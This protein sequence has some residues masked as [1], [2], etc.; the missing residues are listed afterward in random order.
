M[1]SCLVAS[2]AMVFVVGCGGGSGRSQGAGTCSPTALANNSAICQG[3]LGKATT[4]NAD[5]AKTVPVAI[6]NADYTG[7]VGY[8]TRLSTSSDYASFII[9]VTNVSSTARCF[10]SVSS[11]QA[12]TYDLSSYLTGSVGYYGAIY[13][14]TCLGPS[15]TGYLIDITNEVSYTDVSS[16]SLT[17]GDST[18]LTI[19]SVR[20]LPQSFAYNQAS[21]DV[22][23][24]V[25]NTGALAVSLQGGFHQ[26]VLF[27]S[28]DHALD[29]S[30]LDSSS[31]TDLAAGGS[32]QLT[33]SLVFYGRASRLLVVVDF[34]QAS[35]AGALSV[36]PSPEDRARLA[37]VRAYR[38]RLRTTWQARN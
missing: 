3:S 10:I 8:V 34:D 38:T 17:L 19:S 20:V 4:P 15:E 33:D 21:S 12:G 25:R 11:G 24:L 27:D 14:D 37:A 6:S 31:P 7:R 16:I 2:L 5:L 22:S 36:A 18:D 32:E 26:S 1:K 28:D 30:Y 23:I 29:F 9:P 35:V 13:T